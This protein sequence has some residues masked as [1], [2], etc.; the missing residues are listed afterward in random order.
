[1]NLPRSQ[2]SLKADLP[3]GF[4][5]RFNSSLYYHSQSIYCYPFCD[6]PFSD[7]FCNMSFFCFN[8]F[9]QPIS[10]HMLIKYMLDNT[11]VFHMYS[12]CTCRTYI[13]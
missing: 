10:Q 6:I 4:P 8:I 1:M 12:I 13:S 5:D 3:V 2:F 11:F 9:T 7:P